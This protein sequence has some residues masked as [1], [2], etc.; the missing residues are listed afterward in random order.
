MFS[1]RPPAALNSPVAAA[2]SSE[3][4][5]ELSGGCRWSWAGS[6]RARRNS[7][8]EVVCASPKAERSGLAFVG[9]SNNGQDYSDTEVP[10]SYYDLTVPYA[11]LPSF[12]AVSG[13]TPVTVSGSTEFI[14]SLEA[15]CRLDSLHANP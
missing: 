3:L 2:L 15:R 6:S 5:S 7:D 13:G 9:V 14:P 12:G 1:P 10:F 4:S 11:I 8:T